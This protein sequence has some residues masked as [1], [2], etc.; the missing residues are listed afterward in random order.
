MPPRSNEPPAFQ[1]IP[2]P[3]PRAAARLFDIVLAAAA[4]VFFAPLMFLL[5]S[6]IILEGGRPIFFSQVRLG[7]DG[8]PFRMH[9]F[10]KFHERGRL[11]G[12]SL[13]MEDDQR[14]TRV[15]GFLART[16]LDELPQFW[17]ILKGEMSI[18]G[19]RP[20]S[21][22]F[23]DCFDG[24]YGIVLDHKPGIFGPS[25]VLFRNE[26]CLY[27]GCA[28]PEQF[29]RDVLFPLKA[30]I[31]LAYFPHRTLSRDVGWAFRG[32][33]AVFGWSS[34]LPQASL[35]VNYGDRIGQ[36]GAGAPCEELELRLLVRLA[37]RGIFEIDREHGAEAVP[38]GSA[39]PLPALAGTEGYATDRG[40][41]VERR[42]GSVHLAG[43][44]VEIH[45]SSAR[46]TPRRVVTG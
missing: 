20:E 30:Q 18:V 21:T 39:A 25:Q 1:T 11:A 27:R 40:A 37:R 42:G 28:D 16:K 26:A 33:L 5:A 15:G 43:T 6:A 22:D 19:P 46:E 2:T 45:R 36:D 4:L 41:G 32:A 44:D 9:K 38:A 31:D 10:R 8:L 24:S 23:R 12:G 7:R 35:P 14:F 29:Y 13:T 3:P 34:A 17:N